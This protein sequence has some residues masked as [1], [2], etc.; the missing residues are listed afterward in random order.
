MRAHTWSLASSGPLVTS[1]PSKGRKILRGGASL[2]YGRPAMHGGVSTTKKG[3]P[4]PID[5]Q[6][7]DLRWGMPGTTSY[8]AR[9]SGFSAVV[10]QTAGAEPPSISKT[11]LSP[12]CTLP[13]VRPDL[14]PKGK[15][16]KGRAKGQT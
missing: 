10:D 6:G 9:A 3:V 14:K 15:K 7:G 4:V 5:S 13:E 2:M 11:E 1:L 16:K 8:K 12:I